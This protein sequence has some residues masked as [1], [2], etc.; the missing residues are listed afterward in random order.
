V[1]LDVLGLVEEIVGFDDLEEFRL[2]L[3]RALR[4]NPGADV[5]SLNDIGPGAGEMVLL[6]DPPPESFDFDLAGAFERHGHENPLLRRYQETRDGRAYR[7]SDVISPE[8]L[9]KLAVYKAVYAPIGIEYQIAFT[10]QAAP[11]RVLAV[12]LNRCDHDFSDLERDS[13]NRARPIL[14]EL[15]RSTVERE[16]RQALIDDDALVPALREHGITDREATVAS[17]MAHGMSNAA[18]GQALGISART[19]QTHL[20]SAFPK[21]AA[22]TRSE[23]AALSWALVRE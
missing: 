23:A 7:F 20:R 12:A 8:E 6:G 21:L 5:V 9:H 13:L 2:A 3:L 19:V 22:Q 1:I 15:Y 14:I 17:Y 11:N 18:I 4:T 10:L 16:R